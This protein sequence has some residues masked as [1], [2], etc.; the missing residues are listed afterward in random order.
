MDIIQ[1]KS[2]DNGQTCF[3]TGPTDDD[4]RK[5]GAFYDAKS[6]LKSTFDHELSR[7]KNQKMFFYDAR[8]N[9]IYE[10]LVLL[11]TTMNK[12]VKVEICC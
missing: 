6:Y 5:G 2:L 12:S 3:I 1:I 11:F 9:E 7:Y 4:V 10:R 8:P